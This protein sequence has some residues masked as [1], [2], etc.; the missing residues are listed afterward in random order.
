MQLAWQV[1]LAAKS[2]ECPSLILASQWEA[3]KSK[4]CPSLILAPPM[5]STKPRVKHFAPLV[6]RVERR[7]TGISSM[8]T[9]AGK[10]QLVN[11]ILSSLPTYFMCSVQVPVEVLE[12]IDKARRNCLWRKS[13]SNDRYQLLVAWRK[14]TRPKKK[15]GLGMINLRSQNVALLIKH[16]DKFYNRRDIPWVTLIWNTYYSNG[17]VPHAYKKK[18]SFRWRDIL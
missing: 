2:K 15:G 5:G 12:Y 4:E 14:C 11:T 7:L 16:L 3:T 18:V 8:L 13:G 17:E 1:F 6:D 9:H 10:L